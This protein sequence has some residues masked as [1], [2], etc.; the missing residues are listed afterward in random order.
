[1]AT[2]ATYTVG[3]MEEGGRQ[4]HLKGKNVDLWKL[5]FDELE[6]KACLLTGTKAKSHI[7]GV[8]AYHRQMPDLQ[9]ALNELADVAVKG[10]WKEALR[11]AHA[12]E[13]LLSRV[14]KRVAVIQPAFREAA[15]DP[16]LV[17]ADIILS[18]EP[19]GDRRRKQ[20]IDQTEAEVA[21]LDSQ[22]G[23]RRW[24]DEVSRKWRC[25][26]C[27]SMAGWRNRAIY[28]GRCKKH[29]PLCRIPDKR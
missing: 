20:M 27:L 28:K 18:C 10:E 12:H 22:V 16:P 26:K 9:I 13:D 17:A 14:C 11:T 8:K 25:S 2:D 23:H 24:F 19:E 15:T 1:M 5:I 21:R 29:D 4:K 7:D 3:G 6:T